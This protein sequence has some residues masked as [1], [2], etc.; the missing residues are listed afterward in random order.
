M[1]KTRAGVVSKVIVDNGDGTSNTYESKEEMHFLGATDVARSMLEGTY[2]CPE[3]TD[4]FTCCFV[5]ML[6]GL[7][8]WQVS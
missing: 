6:K 7:R 8:Q 5:E 3:G 4:D 1:G 2:V